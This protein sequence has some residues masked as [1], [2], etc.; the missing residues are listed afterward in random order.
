MPVCY[1]KFFLFLAQKAKNYCY[2]LLLG[3]FII[4]FCLRLKYDLFA[5]ESVTFI[6]KIYLVETSKLKIIGFFFFLAQD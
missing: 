2:F 4:F 1:I 5:V 6:R 3:I